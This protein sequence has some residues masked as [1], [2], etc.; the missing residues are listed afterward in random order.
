MQRR[1]LL[2]A[3][4]VLTLLVPAL[5]VASVS[6]S[7]DGMSHPFADEAFEQTWERTDKPVAD[8]DVSR[9]W[10]WGPEPYTEGMMEEYAESPN[11]ERLVQYF[12][13]SRM[14]INNPDAVVTTAC[15]T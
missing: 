10:M 2:T 4:L 11:G 3:V 13:K 8:G 9:T 6:A 5:G 7:H 14:E 15:G 12:D 1:L